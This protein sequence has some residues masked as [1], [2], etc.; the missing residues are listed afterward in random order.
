MN[1]FTIRSVNRW[2]LNV[3]LIL[4]AFVFIL[5]VIMGFLIKATSLL[6]FA[7]IYKI[8]YLLTF[9]WLISLLININGY[10]KNITIQNGNIQG[11]DGIF[12]SYNILVSD[13]VAVHTYRKES[14]LR[15]IVEIRTNY[16]IYR[17]GGIRRKDAIKFMDELSKY[18]YFE[19]SV[20]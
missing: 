1:E 2:E 18:K 3:N 10:N 9:A 12:S 19:R 16:T 5:T 13:V 7:V 11:K 20:G 8:S 17:V 14:S 4:L 15:D 6:L